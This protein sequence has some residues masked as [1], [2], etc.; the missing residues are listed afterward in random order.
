MNE[1]HYEHHDGSIT[2]L[3]VENF[4]DHEEIPD[5]WIR[6][7]TYNV[8][9]KRFGCHEEDAERALKAWHNYLWTDRGIDEV[10]ETIGVP[11]AAIELLHSARPVYIQPDNVSEFFDDEIPF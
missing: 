3:R 7:T 9:C 8:R 4:M 10:G 11:Y 2:V 6:L 1:R 5:G